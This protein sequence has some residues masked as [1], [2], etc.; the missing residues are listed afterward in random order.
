MSEEVKLPEPEEKPRPVT[1]YDGRERW[2]VYPGENLYG[3]VVDLPVNEE[4]DTVVDVAF[5]ARHH[6]RWYP[7]VDKVVDNMLAE[8]QAEPVQLTAEEIDNG[9]LTA[10]AQKLALVSG[11]RSW[12]QSRLMTVEARL[13]ARKDM[14]EHILDRTIAQ[15]A[16][17]D[18]PKPE[19]TSSIDAR[20]ALWIS[21]NKPLR[22]CF[23]E[24]T[25]L[26]ACQKALLQL[27]AMY[28]GWYNTISRVIS[29]RIAEPED[30]T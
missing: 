6:N 17:G 26:R 29:A 25:E 27:V 28:D 12:V 7:Q 14:L 24:L 2:I 3:V 4:G 18:I 19:G 23:M 1:L 10:F 21:Q 5:I 11:Y 13:S 16:N 20:K 22:D 8:L 15:Q 30:R 9:N